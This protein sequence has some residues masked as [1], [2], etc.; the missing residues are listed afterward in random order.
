MKLRGSHL[1][2]I[3]ILAAI[4][5][6]MYTGD[7]IIGGQVDPKTETIAERE[8]KRTS[9]AFRVRV[10]EVQPSKRTE[11]LSIR[12]RTSADA[13]VSVRAETGGT[14]EQRPVSKGQMVKEGDLLCVIDKGVRATT[15]TQ[16]KAQLDQ[17]Q[18]DYD[19]N[20]KLVQRGFATK[21]KL[22]GLRAALDAAKSA[23][24]I[25]EQEMKRTEIRATVAGQVQDPMAEP[26][27]NL[28]SGGICVTLMDTNPMLFSG[29][30]PEREIG[31]VQTGMGAQITLVSGV[32][33]WGEVRY[34]SP[35]ADANT[36]TFTIE[37][38]MPNPERRI[39]DGLTA[40]ARIELPSKEAYK[41]NSNWLTLADNGEIGV[42]GVSSN[43]KVQFFPVT[44]ISQDESTVWAN[45]LKPG[46]RIIT[47]GQNFVSAGQEVEPVTAE[48]MKA[49]ENARKAGEAEQKS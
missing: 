46:L 30:V 31:S 8:A 11:F 42:R 44:I 14:V 24:A 17:A 40:T 47:L 26:G 28:A 21:S 23:V 20:E 41:I 22:R 49:L 13:M 7:L 43:N 5:G 4:S 6:W 45:G 12:G 25:A 2:S 18:A 9:A 1:V 10:E 38:A 27:D 39:L 35:V 48:Q 32:T 33:S 29:Q 36:R 34:I 3:A 16:A 19:A 15:L 37:I